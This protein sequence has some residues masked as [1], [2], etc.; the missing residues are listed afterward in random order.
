MIGFEDLAFLHNKRPRNLYVVMDKDKST[1]LMDPGLDRPWA[2]PSRKLAE[3]HAKENN[4]IV[5]SL[6][7]AVA[8]IIEHPKNRIS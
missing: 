4:G 1:V 5:A 6:D 7:E 3:L 2:S 8:A